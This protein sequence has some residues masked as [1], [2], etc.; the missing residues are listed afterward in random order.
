MPGA[1]RIRVARLPIGLILFR[2]PGLLSNPLTM[3]CDSAG[4]NAI[5]AAP[6]VRA[7]LKSHKPA[8][9][10]ATASGFLQVAVSKATRTGTLVLT[11]LHPPRRFRYSSNTFRPRRRYDRN[12]CVLRADPF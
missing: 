10:A 1:S 8:A 4:A 12:E 5:D 3:E 9:S 11:E 2:P 6:Q 7:E